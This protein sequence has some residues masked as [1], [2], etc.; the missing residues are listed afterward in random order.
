MSL[1]AIGCDVAPK[2]GGDLF[3]GSQFKQLTPVELALKCRHL[4]SMP[5]VVL[6]WDS[7][8]TGPPDPDQGISTLQDLTQRPIEAFFRSNAWDF[9]VP[10]GIS[11]LPYCGCPHWT[12]SQH[13]LGLPRV[14]PFS[15]ALDSLPFQLLFDRP[16]PGSEPGTKASVVEVHPAVAIWLWC[17]EA[18]LPNEAW[19]YKQKPSKVMLLW[20]ALRGRVDGLGALPPPVTDDQLDALVAWLLADRWLSGAGVML[21]GDRRS[22]AFLVP[23]NEALR[24]A[25]DRFRRARSPEGFGTT[26][27]SGGDGPSSQSD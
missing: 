7:P 9:K 1:T 12:I 23:E 22:G 4:S 19:E 25:F 14:G 21:L 18:D 16:I 11:V 10:K 8:L 15:A 26:S 24:A 2:K 17:R 20:E 27:C 13:I 5:G 3:D 6:A